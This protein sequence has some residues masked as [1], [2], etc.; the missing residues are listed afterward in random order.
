[1]SFFVQ[2]IR[3]NAIKS[4]DNKENDD[5]PFFFVVIVIIII[6]IV[7]VLS[8]LIFYRWIWM[9]SFALFAVYNEGE[10]KRFNGT[11]KFLLWIGVCWGCST[12]NIMQSKRIYLYIEYWAH[13][14]DIEAIEWQIFSY[15]FTFFFSFESIFHWIEWN[16]FISALTNTIAT[17]MLSFAHFHQSLFIIIV[18]RL[19]SET[20]NTHFSYW[21]TVQ[22]SIW[23]CLTGPLLSLSLSLSDV[24]NKLFAFLKKGC[25]Q[26]FMCYASIDSHLITN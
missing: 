18:S 4:L 26:A 24:K 12:V 11:H 3:T 2:I 8:I 10:Q 23:K 16:Q 13:T 25:N 5:V 20:N 21:K 7:V 15:Y 1:M 22:Y 14:L 6:N 9:E 17:E 19:Q